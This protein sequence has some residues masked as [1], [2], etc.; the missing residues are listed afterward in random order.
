MSRSKK[1]AVYK[2]HPKG[3]KRLA[4]KKYRAAVR[5]A[6]IKELDPPHMNS[7]V[8]QY[9]VCD[10]IIFDKVFPKKIPK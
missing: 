7:V 5:D 4:Q 9:D 10:Y 2:D 8:N 1:I 6:L 3:A